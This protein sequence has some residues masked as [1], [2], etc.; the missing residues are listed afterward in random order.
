MADWIASC[1]RRRPTTFGLPHCVARLSESFADRRVST[2]FDAEFS[3]HRSDRQSLVVSRC[4]HGKFSVEYARTFP[5]SEAPVADA[6]ES[7][8]FKRRAETDELSEGA[9]ALP[10][11]NV[12]GR[13]RFSVRSSR[14]VRP[15][16]VFDSQSIKESGTSSHQSLIRV[17][18][19]QEV[20]GMFLSAAVSLKAGRSFSVKE[21]AEPACHEILGIQTHG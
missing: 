4:D 14:P 10:F 15:L 1:V 5:I 17:A 18:H 7:A 11:A 12:Q 16:G 20:G 9:Y 13:E 2:R 6:T 3:K 8:L 21:S 19:G